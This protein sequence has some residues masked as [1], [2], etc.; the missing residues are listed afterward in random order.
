LLTWLF[1][2]LVLTY[3]RALRLLEGLPFIII[4]ML[5][6][7]LV[8]VKRNIL[9]WPLLIPVTN[10]NIIWDFHF[11]IWVF[12][13]FHL[14]FSH[15]FY[16]LFDIF[17]WFILTNLMGFYLL[18][19]IMR[20]DSD[21]W[22][23]LWFFQLIVRREM[24]PCHWL[25]EVSGCDAQSLRLRLLLRISIVYVIHV[26]FWIKNAVLVGIDKALR[27]L[28]QDSMTCCLLWSLHFIF[29]VPLGD[30]ANLWIRVHAI[31]LYL[32][33]SNGLSMLII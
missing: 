17:R 14:V 12:I 30:L 5:I 32:L 33:N 20:G 3:D 1:S 24:V 27:R 9:F 23:G 6:Q 28:L 25:C 26:H 16:G 21:A 29:I 15:I 11:L 13:A 4:S 10:R 22:F 31:P 19:A 7:I 2:S 18:L 8:L